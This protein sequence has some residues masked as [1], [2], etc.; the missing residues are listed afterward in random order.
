MKILQAIIKGIYEEVKDRF[1]SNQAVLYS[2]GDITVSQRN[3]RRYVLIL[4]ELYD[5]T[6]MPNNDIC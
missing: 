5:T 3:D 6:L 4:F 2:D 1:K